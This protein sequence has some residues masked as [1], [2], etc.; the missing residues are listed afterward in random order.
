VVITSFASNLHRV[1]QVITA[2]AS[3]D[4]KVCLVGRSM[5]KYVNVA[6]SLGIMEVPEGILVAPREL[7]QFPDERIVIMSTGSQGEP[8]SA[9]RRM[10]HND[11]PAVKLRP[12][13]L[14]IFS[15]TPIPGNERPINETIDRLFRIGCDVL[16]AKDAPIHA[17]G[18]GHAEEVK[19]M[20][21]LTKPRYVMPV[22]GD[23][24][25][26]R[27]H[28]ELAVAMGIHPADVFTG[29]NGLPLEIDEKGARFGDR[30]ASGVVFVDGVD[31][32]EPNDAALRDRR[33][34]SADGLVVVV[35]TVSAQT[36][37]PVSEVEVVLRGVPLPD[38]A[39]GALD[40]LRAATDASLRR[41]ASEEESRDL[42]L[43][44]RT[45][46]D[47]LARIVHD[48]LRRRPMVVPVVVEV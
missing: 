42:G 41:H 29:E 27:L 20:L 26:L 34:L 10:A 35:A 6:R 8:G 17:S 40:D 36:G 45:L 37:E 9:L 1:Q 21:G 23:F 25:R 3:L 31:I 22:H 13:D 38:D 15:A 30:E 39:E 2:A 47:D 33:T 32:G 12:G 43:L 4:R 7:D 11:H 19:L 28:G 46:H 16:T 14:V 48:R 5:R 44:E 18:H 24:K